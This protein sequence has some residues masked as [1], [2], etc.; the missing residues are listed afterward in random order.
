[1]YLGFS[2]HPSV[3]SKSDNEPGARRGIITGNEYDEKGGRTVAVRVVD[4]V[5]R[6]NA[7]DA[8]RECVTSHSPTGVPASTYTRMITQLGAPKPLPGRNPETGEVEYDLD[9]VAKFNAN[10]PGPGSWH[11]DITHRTRMRYDLLAAVGARKLS[12]VID[13]DLKVA[14]FRDGEPYDGRANTRVFTDLRRAKMIEV[15]QV[16]GDVRLTP[17]GEKLLAQWNAEAAAEQAEASEP[18]RQAG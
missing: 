13:P 2:I 1:V 17:E 7:A 16:G 11:K 14:V 9:E 8:G 10:R 5:R 18:A 15:P 6:G 3:S 12:V 4:G